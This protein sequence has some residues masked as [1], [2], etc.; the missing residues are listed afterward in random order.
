MRATPLRP[1]MTRVQ[2]GVTPVP[3]ADIAP[4]PV[5]ATRRTSASSRATRVRAARG[6][7]RDDPA[8]VFDDLTDGLHR[9][10]RLVGNDDL[11]LVLEGEQEVGRIER[12][13]AQFVERAGGR[14]A[15]RIE[16]L[17]PGDDG[18]DPL[19]QY[20]GHPFLPCIA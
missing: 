19:F 13:D 12:V 4:S 7:C 9:A 17:L 3:S 11:E 1:S 5:I 15:R 6:C 16:L 14:Y 2:N 20:V 8:E 18:D 10:R